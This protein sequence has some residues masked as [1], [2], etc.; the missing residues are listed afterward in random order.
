MIVVIVANN[1]NNLSQKQVFI[2]VDVKKRA[3]QVPI[4]TFVRY[5]APF[6]PKVIDWSIEDYNFIIIIVIKLI[7]FIHV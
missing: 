3:L 1:H 6:I 7:I 4:H 2:C 5:H